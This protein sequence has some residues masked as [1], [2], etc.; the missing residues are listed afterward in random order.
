MNNQNIAYN[1]IKFK[2]EN[3][4]RRYFKTH[5][6]EHTISTLYG[7]I[8]SLSYQS[9]FETAISHGM[10]QRPETPSSFLAGYISNEASRL[11]DMLR[12][13]RGDSA[14]PGYKWVWDDHGNQGV[15]QHLDLE[16]ATESHPV[17]LDYTKDNNLPK[18]RHKEAFKF[19]LNANKNPSI[20][21]IFALTYKFK[22]ENLIPSG[23]VLTTI[24]KN[25]NVDKVRRKK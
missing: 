20:N 10:G 13:F 3:E 14:R 5:D 15:I 8:D 16:G 4:A 7:Q 17:F 2:S 19:W 23:T 24:I 11:N 22:M 12:Y 1:P 6:V 25:N 18:T 21:N 9:A